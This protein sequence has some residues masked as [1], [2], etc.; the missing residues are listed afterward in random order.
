MK[1]AIWTKHPGDLLG[2]AIDFLT[3]GSAQHAAFIRADGLIV[4][5]YWPHVRQRVMLPAER[6]FVKIFELRGMTP[7]L[8]AAFE[9]E[10]DRML[11]APAQYSGEDLF[12]FLFNQPNTDEKETFCSRLVMHTT[13]GVCPPELWPLVRCMDGDWVSPRDLFISPNYTPAEMP[14]ETMNGNE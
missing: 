7:E 9:L 4:E 2:E 8:H 14:A 5:A 6:P 1:V 12:R 13:M 3:H 10:F 11:F